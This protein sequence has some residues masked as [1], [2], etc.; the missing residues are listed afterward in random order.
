MTTDIFAI[1]GAFSSPRIFNYL[2]YKLGRSYRWHFLDYSSE[3]SG[4]ATIIN[5][6]TPP[7]SAHV[8]GHSMGG[9][10]ALALAN[11]PWVTSV[12][13]I[14]TPIGGVEINAIQSYLTRSEFIKDVANHSNFILGFKKL[15]IQTPTQHLIS[16]NGF[17]PWLYEP[18]DGVVTIRSQRALSFGETYD[19]SA[20]HA[21]IMLEDQTAERLLAFWENH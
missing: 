11:Q 3:T 15:K 17:N 2:K 20:N 4:L 18:N 7:K 10:I 8:I 13:T 5:S 6:I 16:V 19:I 9:L 14:S 21:E 12:T 1:H